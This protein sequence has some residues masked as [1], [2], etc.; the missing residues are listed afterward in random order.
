MTSL[1]S[2]YK[3]FYK[4]SDYRRLQTLH[5]LHFNIS[6]R[7][8]RLN[9]WSTLCLQNTAV[10]ILLITRIIIIRSSRGSL[11]SSEDMNL[12]SFNMSVTRRLICNMESDF[13]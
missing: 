11:Q 12:D 6:L 4:K 13:V 5:I 9:I 10:K 2:N 1:L 8:D 7:M 3:P